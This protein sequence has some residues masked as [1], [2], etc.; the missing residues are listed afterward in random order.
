MMRRNDAAPLPSPHPNNLPRA[1]SDDDDPSR[2]Q[3]QEEGGT[4]LA[5]VP[6]DRDREGEG[7]ADADTCDGNGDDATTTTMTMTM[8]A[9]VAAEARDVGFRVGVELAGGHSH[10][11]SDRRLKY[12][13]SYVCL[14][15]RGA[16]KKAIFSASN[17]SLMWRTEI[18]TE[19]HIVHPRIS[20]SKPN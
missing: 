19:N 2:H 14:P 13:C 8:T 1:E 5:A 7:D 15:T 3:G 12:Y 4:P 9:A 18:L 17:N 11:W 20:N 16:I 6:H 10:G